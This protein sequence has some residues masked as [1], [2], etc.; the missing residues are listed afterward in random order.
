MKDA[1]M[2]KIGLKPVGE[3]DKILEESRWH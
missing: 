2:Q 3:G 1:D